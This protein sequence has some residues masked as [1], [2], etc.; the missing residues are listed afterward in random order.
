M[1]ARAPESSQCQS[2]HGYRTRP[3]LLGRCAS[4]MANATIFPSKATTMPQLD[5]TLAFLAILMDRLRGVA[6]FVAFLAKFTKDM[7]EAVLLL[8]AFF[9]QMRTVLHSDLV[10]LGDTHR[11]NT[12]RLR[13]S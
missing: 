11:S 9:E 5:E 13:P 6:A 3:L 10:A 8:L 1:V 12:L 2:W 4:S 7:H